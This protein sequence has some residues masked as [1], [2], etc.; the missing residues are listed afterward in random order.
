ML[1][2]GVDTLTGTAGNDTF[3][4]TYDG[5]ATS[6][7]NVSDVLAGGAGTDVLNITATDD[8]IVTLPGA[9]VSGIETVNIRNVDGNATAEVLTVNASNFVGATSFNADRSTDSV[10]FSNLGTGAAVGVIGN[11]TVVGG[12]VAAGYATTTDAVTLNIADGTKMTNGV[13]VTGTATSAT[14]NSTGAANT[15]GTVDLANASLTSVT[16]NAAANLKGD[17]LSQATDQVGANGAVTISGAATTVELTAALDNSIKTINASGLTAGGVKATLGTGTEDYKGG[18]G[19]DTITLNTGVKTATFGAGN[20]VVTT[21]A[22]NTTTAGAISGGDGT[23]TLAVAATTDVDSAAKR[24]VYTSFETLQNNTTSNISAD[25][26]TGV[27]SVIT[28]G[29]NGGFTGLNATQAAAVTNKVDHTAVTLA[30]TT[31][32]GTADVLSVTLQNATATASADLAGATVN[33]FETLNVTSASGNVDETNAAANIVS[34]TAATD[35]TAINVAGAYA[36]NLILDNTS[37]AVTVDNALSGTAAMRVEGEVIKGSSITTTGN[38]DTIETALAAVAG[39]AGEYVTYNAGAGD[40]AISTSLTGLNNVN[41]AQA[42]LKIDGGAGTDTLTFATADATFTDARFQHVTNV[43]KV[44]LANTTALT[45][46]TGGFFDNNFKASGVTLTTGTLADAATA[47]IDLASFTGAAKVVATS[48]GVGN[49]ASEDLSINTGSGADDVTLTASSW[50]G[51]AGA[52]S[53]ITVGTGAGAD[54]ISLTI[55]DLLATTSGNIVVNGGTGADTITVSHTNDTTATALISFKVVDGDS[56]AAARDKITG[57]LKANGTDR[58][59]VLDFDTANVAANTA[60]T[61]GTDS[62][63]IK[64]HAIAS[65]IITFDDIDSFTTAL[66]VNEANLAD[67]LSYVATNISTA[68]NTVAFA[69]DSN[70]DGTADATIVFNQGASDSVIELVGVTGV[71]AIGASAVTANLVA[72]G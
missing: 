5:A 41:N 10:T 52:A 68:G 16:I 48:S 45:F 8:A 38:G 46:T 50:V 57:F 51:V 71:T 63:T 37:K 40:D 64:S 61:N 59:D 36:V 6:T 69:Y 43:E 3:T 14:I 24:A 34:F 30:L 55:G 39:V 60:G 32:T 54:K 44:T 19:V 23:D 20:D 66:T 12:A 13:T 2:T 15:I 4:G 9:L 31:A 56:T 1:T 29:I 25:G 11:G 35:L 21:A 65:G 72:I 17:L 47:T 53:N 22:V 18:A 49:A 28:N 42:S 33:G 58:S 67:V 26:Y 7:F 62:G 27:T 70:S